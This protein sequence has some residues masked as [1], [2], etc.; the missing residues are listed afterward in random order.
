[1]E[2]VAVDALP[3]VGQGGNIEMPN[4]QAENSEYQEALET[5]QGLEASEIAGVENAPAADMSEVHV[6]GEE[7]VPEAEEVVAPEEP[8]PEEASK[9]EHNE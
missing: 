7:P 3:D 6:H 9:P 2:D 5:G 4:V 8:Q 1:V